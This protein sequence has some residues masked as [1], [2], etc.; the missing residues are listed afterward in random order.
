[1]EAKIDWNMLKTDWKPGKFS[2]SLWEDASD[3][4]KI[5]QS[6]GN[7]SIIMAYLDNHKQGTVENNCLKMLLNCGADI[8]HTQRDGENILWI[9]LKRPVDIEGWKLMLNAGVKYEFQPQGRH[10]PG[11]TI[12]ETVFRSD[13]DIKEDIL[14]L[15]ADR[16]FNPQFIK[17]EDALTKWEELT[18]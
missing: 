4:T 12:F 17:N 8:N 1:M 16:G 2:M 14:Q 10:G 5:T 7:V 15:L 9:A 11:E 6:E 18:L 3:V 13:K